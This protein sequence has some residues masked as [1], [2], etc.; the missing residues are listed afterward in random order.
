MLSTRRLFSV[1][2]L[3][4]DPEMRIYEQVILLCKF[5]ENPVGDWGNPKRSSKGTISGRFPELTLILTT[6][7]NKSGEET[8]S[9]TSHFLYFK[10]KWLQWLKSGFQR[11]ATGTSH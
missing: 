2:F 4:P 1:G 8:N 5:E 6:P 10:H 7:G 11:G 9:G 3:K